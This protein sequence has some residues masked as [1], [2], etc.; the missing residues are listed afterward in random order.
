MSTPDDSRLRAARV[1]AVVDLI[2]VRTVGVEAA[3]HG[4]ETPT[5]LRL[6]VPAPNVAW[7]HAE[8]VLTYEIEFSV[9]VFAETEADPLFTAVTR[10]LL[11]YGLP[12][13]FPLTD[14]DA[15]AFG[16]VSAVFSAHP[17]AR[18]LAQ[19]LTV[20]AGLPPLVLG[21]LRS[22]LHE[23]RQQRGAW[24]IQGNPKRYPV[25]DA[26]ADG[27]SGWSITRSR[28]KVRVG[29]RIAFW[30]SGSEAGVYAVGEV[31]EEP[32]EGVADEQWLDQQDRGRPLV[33]VGVHLEPLNAP[34]L[35][36]DLASDE[37]FVDAAILRQ[38]RAGNPFPLSDE[39]WAAIQERIQPPG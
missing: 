28:D 30:V 26:L 3:L 17:Y 16:T 11:T 5:G 24:L 35:K 14:D 1:G 23:R 31:T 9:I 13:G 34:L 21:T 20:R 32:S 25:F 7:G 19:S 18:E 22:P 15:Q 4:L 33:F 2:D 37:R 6:N 29:D 39:E 38:P 12:K 36:A 8:D 10:F 27:I